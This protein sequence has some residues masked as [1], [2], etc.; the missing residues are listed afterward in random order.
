MKFIVFFL[1]LSSNIFAG[2]R[3][4][5]GGGTHYCPQKNTAEFYDLFEA[6]TRYQMGF[7]E[8]LLEFY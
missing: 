6:R 4:G 7:D 8:K 2:D 1:V 5:N 3:V